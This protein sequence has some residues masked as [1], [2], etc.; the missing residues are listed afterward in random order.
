M[1][2]PW[3]IS[4]VR[5]AGVSQGPAPGA[6]GG[7]NVGSAFIPFALP[8]SLISKR[9]QVHGEATGAQVILQS[10]A[11][12]HSLE[13]RLLRSRSLTSGHSESTFLMT[14]IIHPPF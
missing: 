12:S 6:G 2:Q 9:F 11:D 7:G 8:S 14:T 3:G 13:C 1:A 4:C 5:R 10:W